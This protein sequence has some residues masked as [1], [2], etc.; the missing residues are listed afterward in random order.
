MEKLLS[1]LIG[2]VAGIAAAIVFVLLLNEV[3][4]FVPES[5]SGIFGLVHTFAAIAL[6]IWVAYSIIRPKVIFVP[7]NEVWLSERFGAFEEK[8]DSGINV[9]GLFEKVGAMVYMG[10]QVLNL[11]LDEQSATGGRGNVEFKDCS[12]GVYVPIIFRI[13]D[14]ERAS[15]ETNDLLKVIAEVVEDAVRDA[16][17]MYTLDQAMSLKGRFGKE[18]ITAM[19]DLTTNTPGQ[20]QLEALYRNSELYRR[21]DEVGVELISLMIADFTLPEDIAAQRE[22]KLVAE[23]S[24]AVSEIT[25]KET[26]VQ[27]KISEKRA[28]ADG[29]A[30]FLRGQGSNNVLKETLTVIG[31]TGRDAVSIA[32]DFRRCEAIEK[33]GAA[34]NLIIIEGEGQVGSGAKFGAGSNAAARHT[35][36]RNQGNNQQQA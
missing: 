31:A 17:L 7:E 34:G 4:P 29:K 24:L 23:Q 25:L 5:F 13:N 9:L 1:L 28:R 3:K 14:A 6:F 18:T 2:L 16:M 35:A 33:A 10:Q 36:G 12:A 19:I 27:A 30:T 11:N 8:L 32:R 26:E 21:L 22:K 20:Q 15:Y